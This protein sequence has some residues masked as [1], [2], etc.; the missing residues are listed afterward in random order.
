[1]KFFLKVICACWS[2]LA[3]NQKSLLSSAAH[4]L[5]CHSLTYRPINNNLFVNLQQCQSYYF[6]IDVILVPRLLGLCYCHNMSSSFFH[7]P[8]ICLPPSWTRNFQTLLIPISPIFP[9]L[10]Q[11]TYPN[12]RGCYCPTGSWQLQKSELWSISV[13]VN[14]IWPH[15]RFQ[16]NSSY[17]LRHLNVKKNIKNLI[18]I[19][20]DGEARWS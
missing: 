11:H 19:P 17:T 5:Y 10:L 15:S 13:F 16:K 4:P 20:F 2:W 7:R 3:R 18:H 9:Y 12:K 14:N 8:R 6:T 1:M